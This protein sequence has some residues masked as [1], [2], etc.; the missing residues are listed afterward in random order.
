MWSLWDESSLAHALVRHS[1]ENVTSQF[2][3]YTS[4]LLSSW[5]ALLYFTLS[6]VLWR[7]IYTAVACWRLTTP[8]P[9]DPAAG[10]QHLLFQ[11]HSKQPR[12][13][14]HRNIQLHSAA[15]TTTETPTKINMCMQTVIVAANQYTNVT[16]WRLCFRFVRMWTSQWHPTD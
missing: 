6:S 8:C 5:T 12:P 10:P 2:Y 4:V 7:D 3:N 13:P 11:L 1:W 14:K 15:V 16:E 9:Q